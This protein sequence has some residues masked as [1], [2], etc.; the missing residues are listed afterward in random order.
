MTSWTSDAL[1]SVVA[2]Y[3]TALIAAGLKPVSVQSSVGYA[4]RF[5]M[6][7]NGDYQPRGAVGPAQARAIGATDTVRLAVDVEEYSSVLRDAGLKPGAVATYVGDARRF[8]RWLDGSYRPRDHA[9]SSLVPA[10]SRMTSRR[11]H[12]DAAARRPKVAFEGAS[13]E[14]AQVVLGNLVSAWRSAG[15]PPQP[16]I[17]WSQARWQA[18]L[19]QHADLFLVLPNPLDRAALASVCAEAASDAMSA[20]KAFVAVM[21]WGQGSNGYAQYRTTHILADT[22]R[23]ADRLLE[24]AR[25]LRADGAVEAYRRLGDDCRLAGFGPAFGTKLLHFCQPAEQASRALIFDRTVSDWIAQKAGLALDPLQWSAPT[26]SQYLG[27]MHDWAASLECR[28]EDLEM[29]IFR[30]MAR[31][32]NSQWNSD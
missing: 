30:A 14:A 12:A 9:K 31:E 15:M 1:M 7:R 8:V 20:E 2:S 24:V 3:E 17:R 6:W 13:L 18:A 28:S 29:C 26:Y 21:V 22:P 10:D 5:L 27:Q 23:A 4:R 16:G 19:P 25:T 32:R 11:P